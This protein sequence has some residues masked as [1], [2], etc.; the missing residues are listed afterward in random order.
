[1]CNANKNGRNYDEVFLPQAKAK[2][3]VETMRLY[4]HTET[5]KIKT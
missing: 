1:M 4:I 5:I 2:A 3:K